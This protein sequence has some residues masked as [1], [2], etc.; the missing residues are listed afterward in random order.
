[1]YDFLLVCLCNYSYIV[2]HF[3]VIWRWKYRDLEIYVR[4]HWRSLE[5]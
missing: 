4:G 3:Q 1:M 2:Y 5:M